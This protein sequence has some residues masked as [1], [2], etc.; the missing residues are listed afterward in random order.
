M[1]TKKPNIKLIIDPCEECFH[2]KVC[3][4]KKG[5]QEVLKNVQTVLD[6]SIVTI[7][8]ELPKIDLVAR[9]SYFARRLGGPYEYNLYDMGEKTRDKILKKLRGEKC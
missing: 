9:C 5:T 8:E 2:S 1:E 4:M 3:L 7:D 6:N